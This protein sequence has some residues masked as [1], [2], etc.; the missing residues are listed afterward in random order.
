MRHA[1]SFLT[2]LLTSA[3]LLAL[4]GCAHYQP[5]PLAAPRTAADFD[6]RTLADAGLKEFAAANLH[7]ELAAWPPASWDFNTLSLAAFYFHPDLDV[8]RAKWGVAQ[9]GK[10]TAGEQPNPTVSLAPGYNSTI[11]PP[12]ILGLSF[13]IPVETAG[14]RGYR[15]AQARNLS[16]VARLNIATVAWQVRSRVRRS[17]LDLQAAR[18]TEQLLK[19]QQAVQAAIVKSLEGQLA[20]GAV[21]PFEVSQARIANDTTRLALHDAERQAVEARAQLADALGVPSRALGGV[22]IVSENPQPPGL[23]S[24]DVRRQALLNRADILGALAEYAATQAAL[25]LEI[26][27]QYPD[28]H[29]GPGYQL[30][31]TANKWTLGL[32]VTLPVFNQNQGAIAEAQARRVEAAA[33][34]TALQARVV[35]EIDRATATYGAL[36]AKTATAD[37][38]LARLQKQEQATKEMI[39][40]GELSKLALLTTQLEL[41]TGLLAR[42]DTQLKARQALAALEDAVQGPLTE[43]IQ[44]SPRTNP[45]EVKESTKP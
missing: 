1:N 44:A 7:G 18:E 35:G 5:R 42:L 26:A 16:E 22:N 28:V 4:A 29:L 33:R 2:A 10:V 3:G 43:A 11:G 9:A 45:V 31:Q 12:W 30:D 23:P 38:L 41:N 37:A 13:D 20:A 27:K 39:A 25:Q 24:P 14:K 8:A 34:F 40:A 17:L 36:V 19:Q 15:S 6:T 21:T 32:T